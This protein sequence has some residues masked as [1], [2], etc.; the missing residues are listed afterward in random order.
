ME[1]GGLYSAQL[2]INDLPHVKGYKGAFPVNYMPTPNSRNDRPFCF[3]VNDQVD[4]EIGNH[5]MGV[6][7][8]PNA[9]HKIIFIEPLGTPIHKRNSWIGNYLNENSSYFDLLPFG[10]QP[11]FV[12]SSCGHFCAYILYKLQMYNYNLKTLCEREFSP[13]DGSFNERKVVHWWEKE[14]T[15]YK[16]KT[17]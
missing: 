6:C 5:W 17:Y 4:T 12:S 13:I 10:V 3:I 9:K 16:K 14:R 15:R 2:K 1:D 7:Y 8:P 11:H